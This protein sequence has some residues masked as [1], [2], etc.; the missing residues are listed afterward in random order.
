MK[1]RD[2]PLTFLAMGVGAGV[3]VWIAKTAGRAEAWDSL[4]YFSKGLPI[5]FGTAFFLGLLSNKVAVRWAI[6]LIAPQFILWFLTNKDASLTLYAGILFM[7]YLLCCS[8]CAHVGAFVH[9]TVS[10]ATPKKKTKPPET[11]TL[12]PA[13]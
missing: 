8:V 6:F 3:W 11:P 9:F 12:N 1:F 4:E 5:M 2:I 13:T 10:L 7:V